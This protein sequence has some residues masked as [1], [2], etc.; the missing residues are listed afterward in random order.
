MIDIKGVEYHSNRKIMTQGYQ[1]KQNYDHVQLL[2]AHENITAREQKILD[3]LN[4]FQSEDEIIHIVQEYANQSIIGRR[5]AHSI[6]KRRAELGGFK[7]LKELA[8][9]A[10]LGPTKFTILIYALY[11]NKQ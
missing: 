6:L 9:T 8:A 7:N 11:Y 4:S 2:Q 5:I 3:R 1:H 10:R